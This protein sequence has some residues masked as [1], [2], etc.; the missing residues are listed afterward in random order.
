MNYVNIVFSYLELR[1]IFGSGVLKKIISFLLQKEVR[2]RESFNERNMTK[3]H[4]FY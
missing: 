2:R 1:I 3:K 4:Y